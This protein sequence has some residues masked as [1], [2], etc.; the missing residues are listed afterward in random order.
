MTR[1]D[2]EA[3]QRRNFY[4]RAL[5]PEQR[6]LMLEAQTIDGIEDEIALLRMMLLDQLDKRPETYD[7]LTRNMQLLIRA[8][9][10]KYR[11]SPKS[12]DDFAQRV[13]A[14]LRDLG[15]QIAPGL[16]GGD[17]DV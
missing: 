16:M 5:S 3:A 4:E 9:V 10:V 11:L 17:A 15:E 2:G 7:Q 1:A 13:T 8:V 12:A 6:D 14:V